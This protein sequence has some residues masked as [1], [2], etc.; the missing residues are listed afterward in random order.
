MDK[1]K[2]TLVFSEN[3]CLVSYEENK[4]FITY[5]RMDNSKIKDVAFF[6]LRSLKDIFFRM[7]ENEI[8]FVCNMPK[9][10]DE[11]ASIT[12]KKIC[13]F[14]FAVIKNTQS[15]I[16]KLIKDE[17]V[18]NKNIVFLGLPKE[19]ITKPKL[20][21]KFKG[22]W[23]E[24]FYNEYN[25]IREGIFFYDF[26]SDSIF[27]SK[28]REWIDTEARYSV[29][30][31]I[32]F[33]RE[34]GIK[35]I[36]TQNYYLYETYLKAYKVFLPAILNFVGIEGIGADYDPSEYGG[37]ISERGMFNFQ[38]HKRFNPY[39]V[40][41]EFWD[42][43]FNLDNVTYSVFINHYTFKDENFSIK[44]D[45]SLLV[46]S[47]S[48]LNSVKNEFLEILFVLTQ[49]NEDNIFEDFQTWGWAMRYIIQNG[50][51]LTDTQRIEFSSRIMKLFYHVGQFLKYEVIESFETDR[52]IKIYGDKDW[53]KLFPEFYQNK[54]LNK[55]EIN[56]LYEG[57]DKLL[58][59]FNQG[60]DYLQSSGPVVDAISK[61]IPFVNFPAVIKTDV[62][63]G[64]EVLE[65][66]N[67]EELKQKVD[68]VVSILQDQ[69][70]IDTLDYYKKIIQKSENEVADYIFCDKPVPENGG[71]FYK[72]FKK[73]EILFN[74]K[75]SRYIENNKVFLQK[76]IDIVLAKKKFNIDINKTRFYDRR[77]MRTINDEIK[78]GY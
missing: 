46:L 9:G 55:E 7:P 34:K 21:T 60:V 23:F 65:Y 49:L 18:N 8:A 62:L 22:D 20:R 12:I 24:S 52:T 69:Q 38:N 74:E 25:N 43:K 78:S 41:E 59:N 70:L 10:L 42:K 61:N 39:P 54:F 56:R 26:P 33:F 6:I 30:E 27:D 53:G 31:L 17:F 71:C 32:G 15:E 16:E 67:V 28:K 35:K 68:N 47:N 50:L 73:H 36:V 63:K 58:I 76:S 5:E 48:R 64:F 4:Y 57:Q 14:V 11:A 13:E 72:E 37:M 29:H 77:Y 2:I 66:R 45:Y 1:I 51:N 19:I 3:K 40:C 44:D 75:I